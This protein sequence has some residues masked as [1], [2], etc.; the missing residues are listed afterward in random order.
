MRGCPLKEGRKL[1]LEQQRRWQC[2][3]LF[4]TSQLSSLQIPSVKQPEGLSLPVSQFPSQVKSSSLFHRIFFLFQA[5]QTMQVSLSLY[6]QVWQ[7]LFLLPAISGAPAQQELTRMRVPMLLF[8]TVDRHKRKHLLSRNS[9][10]LSPPLS[11]PLSLLILTTPIEKQLL[12]ISQGTGSPFS[13]GLSGI[14]CTDQRSICRMVLASISFSI[15]TR[16]S[17]S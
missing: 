12:M 3:Y 16:F 9:K 2:V 14:T 15:F 17:P 8:L 11:L 13:S 1:S 10:N 4:P 7:F 6:P 5:S